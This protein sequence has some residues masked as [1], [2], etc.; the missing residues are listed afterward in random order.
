MLDIHSLSH[1]E[2]MMIDEAFRKGNLDKEALF[3]S[4]PLP[5]DPN[6]S[7]IIPIEHS[8]QASSIEVCNYASAIGIEEAHGILDSD[9]I[10]ITIYACAPNHVPLQ[11][12]P[13][14][15]RYTVASRIGLSCCYVV[16][17]PSNE[18]VLKR[19]KEDRPC[20][21]PFYRF[22][23]SNY[24][25][26]SKMSPLI[27]N[28][29]MTFTIAGKDVYTLQF[30]YHTEYVEY[31]KVRFSPRCL[32]KNHVILKNTDYIKPEI[33]K[34]SLN[35]TFQYM[36]TFIYDEYKQQH[37]WLNK[38]NKQNQ[39]M[40]YIEEMKKLQDLTKIK[41]SQELQNLASELMNSYRC[42]PE[43]LESRNPCNEIPISELFESTPIRDALLRKIP[44]Q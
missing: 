14:E 34:N 30:K 36:S 11:F 22:I 27:N 41:S 33:F 21:V 31:K 16:V 3:F 26:T 20:C 28:L 7:S 15:G 8:S 10:T 42:P 38:K 25:F 18:E 24:S 9:E 39:S 6:F 37:I 43:I 12:I 44:H 35:A 19:A 1:H 29:A 40:Q 4:E 17:I 32:V 2:I 23:H 13:K 5:V